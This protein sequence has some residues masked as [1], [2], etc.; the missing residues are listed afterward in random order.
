MKGEGIAQTEIY[1]IERVGLQ[2]LKCSAGQGSPVSKG[3]PVNRAGWLPVGS[4]V[5]VS[6]GRPLVLKTVEEYGRLDLTL[7]LHTKLASI[8]LF[9]SVRGWRWIQHCQ[10]NLSKIRFSFVK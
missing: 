4:G 10:G 2:V 5:C 3:S 8:Y 9:K 7:H 6:G 1:R